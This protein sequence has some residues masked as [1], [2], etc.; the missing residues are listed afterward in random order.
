[1]ASDIKLT[2]P[3]GKFKFRVCGIVKIQDK[4]LTVIINNNGF[5]SLPGGHLEIGEDT[6]TGVLREMKEELG[7]EV[8]I[9]KLLAIIQN[10]FSDEG[11]SWHE[12][13][14]YYIVAPKNKNVKPENTIKMEQ[15]KD[16]IVKLDFQWYTLEE[17]I[18]LDFRP[19]VLKD[20][21]KNNEFVHIINKKDLK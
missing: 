20:V 8:K 10:F 21:I 7:Y 6:E 11:K 12:L 15:D 3:E 16:S 1:M 17:L 2:T 13:G 4:Y 18:N 9:V 14:Y 5:N 19:S